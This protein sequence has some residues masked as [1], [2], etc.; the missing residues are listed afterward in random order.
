MIVTL[1][2]NPSVDR[3]FE[4]DAIEVGAVSRARTVRSEA[5]GKG[6]NVA[7]T[8][9]AAGRPVRAVVPVGGHD[10]ALL[11]DE[12]AAR[13]VPVVAVPIAGTVRT[14]ISLVTPDGVVSKI[15]APGPQLTAE[16]LARLRTVTIAALDGATWVA[17]CGSL[18]PG[19]PEDLYAT[20]VAEVRATGARVAIDA[21]GPALRAAV[22]AGPDLVKPNRDELAELVGRDLVSLGDVIAA[23]RE[24]L[25]RGVGTVVASLGADGAVLVD[26][27]GAWHAT[28]PPLVP[29][30]AVGAGDALLAGVLAAGGDGPDA[31][32]AGVAHGAAAALLPG[33]AAPRPSDLDLDAVTVTDVDPHRPLTEGA[34]R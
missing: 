20:L 24:L 11:A 8:L 31:L 27:G 30:S 25:E 29:R 13:G 2:P 4:V 10:G 5:G 16:E 17:G 28:R 21:S 18:P 3:T 34:H 33:T 26:D 14:N 7:R 9:V 6:L 1:T 19:A 22:D 32:L 23:A 15:N 12:L